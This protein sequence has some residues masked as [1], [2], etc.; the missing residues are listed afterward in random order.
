MMM[1][2]SPGACRTHHKISKGYKGIG[3][4]FIASWYAKITQILEKEIWLEVWLEKLYSHRRSK[5]ILADS[6]QP[7]SLNIQ[8]LPP[9]RS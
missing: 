2:N 3:M 5:N 4:D 7:Y 8:S 9:K 1:E 6:N